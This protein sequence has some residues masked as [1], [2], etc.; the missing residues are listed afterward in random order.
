[1]GFGYLWKEND[2]V[3]TPIYLGNFGGGGGTNNKPS[4]TGSNGVAEWR[5]VGNTGNP[6]VE[7]NS[8][9]LDMTAVVTNQALVGIADDHWDSLVFPEVT[10]MNPHVVENSLLSRITISTLLDLG[11][12]TDLSKAEVITLPLVADS[13]NTS[14]SSIDRYS[15]GGVN[16][17]SPAT[18]HQMHVQSSRA[19]TD[20]LGMSTA[21]LIITAVFLSIVLT[22][23]ALVL[24]K[25]NNL[26]P[27]VSNDSV[28]PITTEDDDMDSRDTV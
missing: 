8:A 4:Y 15:C 28:G 9:G 24:L 2:Y 27:N 23:L 25:R 22:F 19:D 26:K 17:V 20:I 16:Q 11:Y 6:P 7:G 21:D 12:K 3:R 14:D 1:M 18:V 13:T 5:R 10:L